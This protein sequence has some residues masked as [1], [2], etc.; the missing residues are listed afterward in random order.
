MI[1]LALL[2]LIS[3]ARGL[4]DEAMDRITH[5]V[6]GDTAIVRLQEHDIRISVFQAGLFQG[7]NQSQDKG[8]R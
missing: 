3:L 5:I 7:R 1:P 4:P 8:I 2:L 6:D